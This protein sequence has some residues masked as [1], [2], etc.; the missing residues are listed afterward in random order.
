MLSTRR[1]FTF[2]AALAALSI[3]VSSSA[4]AKKPSGGGGPNGETAV[5]MTIRDCVVGVDCPL[6][7]PDRIQSDTLGVYTGKLGDLGLDL[8]AGSRPDR[9]FWLDFTECADGPC[10]PPW[11]AHLTNSARFRSGKVYVLDQQTGLYEPI[12]GVPDFDWR[13]LAEGEDVLLGIQ[14]NF[15]RVQKGKSPT[16]ILRFGRNGWDSCR[17]TRATPMLIQRLQDTA[18][19]KRQWTMD[20][21]EPENEDIVCL[22]ERS[23]GTPLGSYH[24]R[25]SALIV[26]E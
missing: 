21:I 12:T 22:G 20:V 8:S 13:T 24:M 1:L 10:D 17:D 23:E 16:W 2:P 5:T 18:E 4:F 25:F 19:G 11:D 7:L 3:L 15:D 9:A 14:L 6:Q 26:E